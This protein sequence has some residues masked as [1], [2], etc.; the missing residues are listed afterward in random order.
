MKKIQSQK[1]LTFRHW[2]V[3]VPFWEEQNEE[4]AKFLFA[5]TMRKRGY[6]SKEL[7]AHHPIIITGIFASAKGKGM[8][9]KKRLNLQKDIDK[10]KTPKSIKLIKR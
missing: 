5:D 4:V 8:N 1:Y 2:K 10:I 6:I 7:I 3:S 9:Y